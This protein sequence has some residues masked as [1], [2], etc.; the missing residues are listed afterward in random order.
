MKDLKN[1]FKWR[2]ILCS[3]IGRFNLVRMTILPKVLYTGL[4]QSL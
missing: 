3:W 4:M 1:I 2:Y